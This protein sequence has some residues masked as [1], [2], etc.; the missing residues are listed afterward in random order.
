MEVEEEQR[1]RDRRRQQESRPESPPCGQTER[2]GAQPDRADGGRGFVPRPAHGAGKRRVLL[3]DGISR[4][5]RVLFLTS[6]FLAQ[7]FTLYLELG[8]EIDLN[9]SIQTNKQT[10]LY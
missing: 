5:V 4:Y 7:P 3:V 2:E 10:T 6:I 8:N 9:L 1:E